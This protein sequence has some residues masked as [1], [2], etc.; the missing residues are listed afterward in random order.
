MP[1]CNETLR[2]VFKYEA[3]HIL[4]A[5]SSDWGNAHGWKL[6][7]EMRCAS[8]NAFWLEL[9]PNRLLGSNTV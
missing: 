8:G 7:L 2:N 1:L 9:A 5:Q 4:Y 3:N 6:V